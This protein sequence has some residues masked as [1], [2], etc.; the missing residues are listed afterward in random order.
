LGGCG[1]RAETWPRATREKATSRCGSTSSRRLTSA[2]WKAAI[3]ILLV[4]GNLPAIQDRSQCLAG[5]FYRTSCPGPIFLQIPCTERA[6][7]LRLHPFTRRSRIAYPTG[8]DVRPEFQIPA[9]HRTR[10]RCKQL[11][12]F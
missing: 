7:N 4:V 1:G 3:K 12:F 6:N 5:M 11:G 8:G 2:S 9:Y 10:T